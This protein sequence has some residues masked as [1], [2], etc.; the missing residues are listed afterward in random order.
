[1]N[2]N[3]MN[4]I[5]EKLAAAVHQQW[6]Q[7]R[8]EQG[9]TYGPERNDAQKKHPCM[10]PYSELPESEKEYDRQTAITTI[11]QIEN[12]GYKIVPAK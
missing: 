10:V 9:W 2:T 8:A 6:M 11:R 4:E 12:A 5:I 7:L 1:M 3:T